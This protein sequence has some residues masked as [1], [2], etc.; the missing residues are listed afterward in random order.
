VLIIGAGLA[1]LAAARH[2]TA[3]GVPCLVLEAG[4]RVGGRIK[5][6]IVRGFQLDRGF[7][8][9]LT[10]YEEPGRI[11]DLDR[12]R[13]KHFL[14]GSLVRFGGKFHA[15]MDPVRHPAAGLRA[16]FTPVLRWSDGPRLT[17]LR[18]EDPSSPDG[19]AR[20]TTL[21][22]LRARGLSSES[23]DRF[24]RPFFGG[25]FLDHDLHTG[26]WLFRFLFNRFAAGPAGLPER[27]MAEIPRVLAEP[28]DPSDIR[29][30]CRVAAINGTVVQL[31]GGETVQG[32]QI[33]VATDAAGRTDLLPSSSTVQWNACTTLYFAAEQA[34]L[35]EPTL[36]LNGEGDAGGPIGTMCVPSNVAASYAPAGSALI[37]VTTSRAFPDSDILRDQ[38]RSQLTAWFGAQVGRWEHLATYH[39]P[40]ALPS[41]REARDPTK[42]TVERVGDNV[43]VCGDYL[44]NPSIDGAM[45]SGRRAA[46]AVLAR[47]QPVDSRGD[48]PRPGMRSHNQ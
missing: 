27:G 10:S 4:D 30:N 7:Q 17:K 31:E 26:A 34:P 3:Q 29:L 32:S 24:F 15:V 35:D 28:L 11:L 42:G 48:G 46:E 19:R 13:L 39:I 21:E 14:S 40:R 41:F 1:G 12:L 16:L 20:L 22:Y 9:F 6:D 23:I 43:I 37:S 8:V 25:V 36:L 45:V 2:L 44:E 33:V 5:T 18:L 38:V 47:C